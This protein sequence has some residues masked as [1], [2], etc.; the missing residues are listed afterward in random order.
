MLK[1]KHSFLKKMLLGVDLCMV[2]VAFYSGYYLHAF[3]FDIITDTNVNHLYPIGGYTWTVPVMMVLWGGALLFFGEYQALRSKS[4]RAIIFDLFRAGFIVTVLFGWFAYLFKLEYISRSFITLVFFLTGFF[5]AVERLAIINFLRYIRRKGFNYR[6]VL[7]VG[8][9][10]RAI[11]VIELFQRHPDWGYR[12]VGIVDDEEKKVGAEIHGCR[13]IG[14]LKDLPGLLTE[15]VIDEVFFVVPRNWLGKIEDSILFCEQ[16]GKQ[17]SVAVDYFNLK[18]AKAKQSDLA[19]FP[20]LSFET[21][22]DKML[23]LFVKRV[24]DIVISLAAL[25]ALSPLFLILAVLVKTT[26]KGGIFFRQ[27]RSGLNGRRFT[28]YKFRTMSKDAEVLLDALKAHNEMSGPVFKMENDP[29][30]TTVGKWMR[31]FSLDELPQLWN[32]FRGDMSIVGPRPPIPKEVKQYE[33]W[34][35][36]RLSMAPGITCLWQAGGRNQISEFDDWMKLDLQYIDNWSLWLDF[37]IVAKTIPA[38]LFA[39]GAK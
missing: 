33:H 20:F 4:V 15:N 6:R 8:S 37:K 18:F 32:T 23:Q 3:L 5:I 27:V 25:I 17:V 1:E 11:R 9:G 22:S 31:K 12:V 29:R 35:R 30:V 2:V 13:I 16:V 24:L 19:G 21:T 10:A 7:L 28:L 39:K 38:V 26:S 34:H 36:R 14:M